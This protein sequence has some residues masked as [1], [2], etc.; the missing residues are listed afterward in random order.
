MLY[1]KKAGEIPSW[2]VL[3]G[4]IILIAIPVVVIILNATGTEGNAVKGWIEGLGVPSV[5]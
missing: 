2:I 3:L 5:P 4:V 1:D